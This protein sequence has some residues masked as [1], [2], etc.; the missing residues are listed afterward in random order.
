M[1]Q[2]LKTVLMLRDE[3]SEEE[4]RNLISEL[5]HRVYEGEDPE[6]LLYEELG[7]EPDYILDLI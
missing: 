6:E 4:A 7:L 2:P 1:V 3:M 5:Q